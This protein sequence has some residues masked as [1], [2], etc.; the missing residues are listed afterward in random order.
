[1]RYNRDKIF[2]G[3]EDLF[4]EQYDDKKDLKDHIIKIANELFKDQGYN[5]TSMENIAEKSG[6]SRRTLFRLF[7]SK[8]EIL[9]LSNEDIIRDTLEKYVGEN[10]TLKDIV[11]YIIKATEDITHEDKINYINSIKR[12]RDEPDLRSEMLYNM[13]KVIQ[14]ISS[15][16]NDMDWV[17]TGAFIGT[18]IA[19]WA[20][21][22]DEP[23]LET[24]DEVRNQL[25]AFR[26]HFL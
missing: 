8:S 13:I 11:D 9:F 1:M 10:Y 15:S 25:I 19:G 24:L 26:K 4:M 5:R 3:L 21:H 18:V 22:F 14:T 6:T 12:V 7:K 23:N 17:L 16:E 2:V 20:R